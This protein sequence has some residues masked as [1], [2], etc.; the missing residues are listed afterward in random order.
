[1]EICFARSITLLGFGK[2]A[3][4]KQPLYPDLACRFGFFRLLCLARKTNLLYF[5]LTCGHN[6][7]VLLCLLYEG[8][9]GKR[10]RRLL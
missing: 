10:S 2:G 5:L 7:V 4:G 9:Y 3:L 8:K 1:M 6:G